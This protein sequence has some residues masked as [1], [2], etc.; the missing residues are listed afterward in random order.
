MKFQ[1]WL[2][3]LP[4]VQDE[5]W[6]VRRSGLIRNRDGRCP[7]CAVLHRTHGWQGKEDA[8]E[9]VRK[10]FKARTDA[11][12]RVVSAADWRYWRTRHRQQLLRA[13]HLTDPYV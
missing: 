12:D 11:P 5:G 7:I 10:L 8:Y 3:L 9:A 1:Q 2:A 4:L 6:R 13:L